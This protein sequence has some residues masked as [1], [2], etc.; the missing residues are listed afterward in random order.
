VSAEE[1]LVL[2]SIGESHTTGIWIRDLRTKT[3]LGEAALKKSL[4]ILETMKLVKSIKSAGAARKRVLL[5]FF[6]F[7]FFFVR[8]FVQVYML[9]DLE[10]DTSVVGGSLYA[11]GDLDAVFVE[12][13]TEQCRKV[14]C[15]YTC[16][17]VFTLF[18]V[19]IVS[20]GAC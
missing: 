12:L 2:D 11:E 10:P 9:F 13:I 4:K 17:L 15:Q 8:T 5:S 3:G 6:F 20:C 19:V 14:G 7:V 18:T 1:Q 16:S